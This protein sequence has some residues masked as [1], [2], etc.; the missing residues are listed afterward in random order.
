MIWLWEVWLPRKCVA[1]HTCMYPFFTSPKPWMWAGTL[2]VAGSVSALP[3]F[4]RNVFSPFS[5]K[6]TCFSIFKVT[7]GSKLCPRLPC[8]KGFPKNKIP[9]SQVVRLMNLFCPAWL[10]DGKIC[11]VPTELVLSVLC[12]CT[13][14]SAY[15]CWKER[16]KIFVLSG[17]SQFS[18][19]WG[20]QKVD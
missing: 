2:S 11:P 8:P 15:H 12:W 16:C 9:T 7:V 10:Y 4:H 14:G 6:E 17:E 18:Q 3:D 1:K 20:I 5:I 13:L 19:S